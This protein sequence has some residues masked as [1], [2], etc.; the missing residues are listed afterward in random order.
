MSLLTYFAS[1][2]I[3]LN[4]FLLALEQESKKHAV[5]VLV[6][7]MDERIFE[8]I[9][10]LELKIAGES[11][12]FLR[13]ALTPRIIRINKEDVATK[14]KL[15]EKFHNDPLFGGHCGQKRLLSKLG[16]GRPWD[17]RP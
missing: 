8:I 11:V 14:T 2:K 15:L 9:S 4:R 6:L 5:N 17:G 12:R 16:I 3:D 13:I 10:A 7:S 1:D